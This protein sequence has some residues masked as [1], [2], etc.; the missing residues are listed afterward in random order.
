MNKPSEIIKFDKYLGR[1]QQPNI[2]LMNRSFHILGK[3]SR[4]DNWHA[5]IVANGLNEIVFN[6]HKYADGRLCPIWDDLVDLKIVDVDGFGRFEIAVNYT[7]NT[8]TV[9]SVHGFSLENELAQIYLNDFHVND[10]EA[11][12]MVITEYSKDNYDEEGNFIPTVFYDKN[13][14]KHSL[15][16]RVLAD[17]APHWVCYAIYCA[18]GRCTA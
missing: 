12:D 3:I 11:A 16:H 6:V 13:D 1:I 17:K 5:S 9:K 15:L 14:E 18:W 7:D 10:E 8:E 4:Y 2:L